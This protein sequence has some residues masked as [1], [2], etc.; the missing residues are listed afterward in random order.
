M[1]APT[2]NTTPSRSGTQRLIT[3]WAHRRLRIVAGVRFAAGVFLAGFGALMLSR[4]ADA[5]AA[6]LLAAAAVNF[7]GLLA[8]DNRPL[9]TSP[10]RSLWSVTDGGSP[11]VSGQAPG[12]ALASGT[13]LLAGDRICSRPRTRWRAS[14]CLIRRRT[15]TGVP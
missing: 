8:A 11:H 14:R 7:V 2:H 15:P 1:T 12:L 10:N 6:L 3:P 9:R 4:G 5:L 13:A